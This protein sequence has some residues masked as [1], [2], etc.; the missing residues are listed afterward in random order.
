MPFL[1][2]E[3]ANDYVQNLM[4]T[5]EEARQLVK[6]HLT[7]AQDKDRCRYDE[8][9]RTVNYNDGDLVWIFTPIRKVGLSEKLLKRYFGPL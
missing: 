4:M 6:I 1:P 7:R 8:R 5:P 3:S 2:D 9:H